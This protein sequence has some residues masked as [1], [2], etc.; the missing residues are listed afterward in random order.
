MINAKALLA[1][2]QRL[3]VTLESDLRQ[4]C[5]NQAEVDQPLHDQYAAAKAANR[6]AQA[7]EVWRDEQI[8]QAGVA[9]ILGCVFVRFCEDNHLIDPPRLSGPGERRQRAEDE[10]TLYFQKHP[11]HS[12]REYLQWVFEQVAQLPA[13]KELFDKRHNPLW[14]LG[15]SGDGAMALRNFFLR[16]DASTGLLIHDF[17]D[18]VFSEPSCLSASVPPCL[19][20]DPTRFL[21]DL[22]QDLS[23]SARKKFALLQTPVFVEE[24]I[25]DRTL[26]PAIAEFGFQQVRMI[27]PTCGSGHF[28]LGGFHRLFDLWV[29]HEPA[30]NI[31]VL[32]QRALDGV[33]GVDLNP[34]AVAIARF[35]L[36]VAALRACDIHRLADAPGFTIHVAAGDSL[37]HGPLLDDR[38]DQTKGASGRQDFMF[39]ADPIGHVYE[40]EDAPLLRNILGQRYHAVVGNPPYITP[41][42]KA[43]N[44]EYRQKFGS[45][46][47]KYSLAV[48]FFQRFFDLAVCLSTDTAAD[49]RVEFPAGFVGMITSNSFM[50]REFGKKLIE[51]YIPRWELTHVVDTAG[52]YIP[53]HGTPTVI[54]FGRNRRPTSSTIR[55]VM[56]IKGEPSTPADPARGN[57]WSA[58]LD[59][60]DNPGTQSAFVSV[61]DTDLHSFHHHPWSIGG[62]GAAELKATLDDAEGNVLSEV[63]DRTGIGVVT[64]EDDAFSDE[65]LVF[66]RKGLGATDSIGFVEG[67]RIRDWLLAECVAVIFPYDASNR[68]VAPSTPVERALWPLKTNLQNRAWF[69]KTQFE[70]GLAWYEYG[71]L[72]EPLRRTPLSIVFA[73]VATHNHFLLDRGGKVFK[74]T[75]PIIKL[76]ADATVDQ[77][78]TLLGLLNSSTTC[79]WMKQVAHQKQMMGGDGIRI[80]ERS[81]VP[82]A[83]NGTMLANLPI[84]AAWLSGKLRDRMQQLADRQDQLSVQ[85][86]ALTAKRCLASGATT[87]TALSNRW[88]DWTK[89]RQQ[90]RSKMIWLQEEIDFTC[91]VMFGLCTEA[92][93]GPIEAPDQPLL[94]AGDR[95]FCIVAQRNVDG[96]S[97]PA[98]VSQDWPEPARSLWLK[99][100]AA[101]SQSPELQLIEEPHYKRR[102]IGI[103]GLFNHNRTGNELSDACGIWLLGRLEGW[104]L[105][106]SDHEDVEAKKPE[107]L[108]P[109]SL[110]WDEKEPRVMSVAQLADRVRQDDDFMQVA[111]LYRGRE[112]FDLTK[113]VAELVEDEAVPA[114]A[115]LRYKE[116]GLRNRRVWEQVW[117]LQQLE[118]AIDA[119]TK[120]DPSNSS[121]QANPQYL[122]EQQA[123]AEKKAKVGDIPVPP[124][125]KS[126]DMLPGPIWRLRGKLDVPK[127]RFV[128]FPHCQRDADPTLVITWAGFDHLQQ[129]Q[130]VA[131]YY[132]AMKEREGWPPER[133]VPLLAAMLELLPWVLQ[134][135]NAIH[136]DFG[137][138]L[139]DYYRDFINDEAKEMG[140]T[141]DEVRA[142]AP[143]AK[144]ASRGR[145]GA[146]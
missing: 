111:A 14:S 64:L 120:L 68:V 114:L 127:E 62:G 73:E 103:Q 31:R 123:K 138:G 136:P 36:L 99:R 38:G 23:E 13:M 137:V 40:T 37:L 54:L 19:P 121:G 128:S 50:K 17:T 144:G 69:R 18:P 125:Y 45:C 41:K 100:I 11:T 110:L 109:R 96:F 92:T 145:K 10:H 28:L 134:W 132:M 25:L 76:P 20:Q 98:S 133:R 141:V 84:P 77:H 139:G 9:W 65:P 21:G 15:V 43:L 60:I 49:S 97:V 46:H 142:W 130:A 102:W 48:P 16:R 47:M 115:V 131:A 90:L 95:P 57:V 5:T 108:S 30:T 1:D 91:Y 101:I 56:G 119:R 22:Y 74:N 104:P 29:K 79:F 42:D 89:I 80:S 107:A 75:A 44:E 94:D 7:Y 34:Y 53:G 32:A 12:D 106:V 59:Q 55:A 2:L 71:L 146:E 63:I 86:A 26:T 122:T 78:L 88:A 6:T 143:P 70:R 72:A 135:H 113:L 105:V 24:F 117:D 4:R 27:D 39:G 87:T 35:R 8:T 52:A 81:K 66:R 93:L 124:K 3:L 118:D 112:D 116:S 140:K 126:A 67:D 51:Q 61:S 85:Y 82:Y 83:F 129:L 58:I 33:Y